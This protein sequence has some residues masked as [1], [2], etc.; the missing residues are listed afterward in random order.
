M[1][2]LSIAILAVVL[3]SACDR[4]HDRPLDC[5]AYFEGSARTCR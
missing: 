2:R 4:S 5:L 3:L 1:K